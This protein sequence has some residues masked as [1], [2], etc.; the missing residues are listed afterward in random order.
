MGVIKYEQRRKDFNCQWDSLFQENCI[1]WIKRRAK[2]SRTEKNNWHR[3]R[4]DHW[5]T[6]GSQRHDHQGVLFWFVK[7]IHTRPIQR[8]AGHKYSMITRINRWLL[9][10]LLTTWTWRWVTAIVLKWFSSQ[11]PLQFC[12]TSAGFLNNIYFFP[13]RI[14][15]TEAKLPFCGR[16]RAVLTWSRVVVCFTARVFNA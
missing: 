11:L 14:H 12:A 7:F 9:T 4:N 16:S 5:L 8:F 10:I 13:F 1:L 3:R 2:I 6:W 15:F